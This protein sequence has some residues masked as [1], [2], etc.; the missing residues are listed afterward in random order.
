MHLDVCCA[1]GTRAEGCRCVRTDLTL[2]SLSV[3]GINAHLT[4]A[5]LKG[6]AFSR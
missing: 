3:L 2:S 1:I 6:I 4:E 5:A